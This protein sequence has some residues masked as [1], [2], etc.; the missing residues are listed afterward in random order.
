MP[1]YRVCKGFVVESG[2]MLSRHPE[3]CRFPHGHTRTVE[4][5]VAGDRLDENGMLADYTALKL[6]IGDFVAQFDHSMALNSADPLAESVGSICPQGVVVF[7][8]EEPTTEAIA[9]RIFDHVARLLREGCEKI[10]EGGATYRIAPG[11]VT[12]ERVRVSETP[13]TWAEYGD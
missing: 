13:T 11:R 6:A 8:N 1:K 10:S 12:L 9:R 7:A 2:H 3:R 4:I 5:V